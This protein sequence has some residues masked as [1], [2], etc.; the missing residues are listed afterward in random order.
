MIF[1]SSWLR[2]PAARKDSKSS[3]WQSWN[4]VT[5]DVSGDQ[6]SDVTEMNRYNK[7]QTKKY[8]HTCTRP[9][10]HIHIHRLHA[11]HTVASTG[12]GD[13]QGRPSARHAIRRLTAIDTWRVTSRI[14]IEMI[15]TTMIVMI[16]PVC[17]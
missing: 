15:T 8:T 9:H 4:T 16:I 13:H 6:E 2:S 3:V 7:Y 11:Q 17:Q 10:T 1:S 12:L 14:I 5:C